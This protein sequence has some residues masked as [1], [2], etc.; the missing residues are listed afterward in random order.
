MLQK[1]NKK[2]ALFL[3]SIAL[4]L[5][6]IANIS[7]ADSVPPLSPFLVNL[8]NE[9]TP[10]VSTNLFQIPNL[11]SCLS[12]KT[13]AT[14]LFSCGT[15][16]GGGT[17]STT[18]S[19]VPGE[20][21][22]FSNN[23]TDIVTVGG[24]ST[25][26]AKFIFDPNTGV[27][28][29]SGNVVAS[30]TTATSTFTNID[31]NTLQ[32]RRFVFEGDSITSF[33]GTPGTPNTWPQQLAK[34]EP[35]FGTGQLIDV[36]QAGDTMC[37]NT[38]LNPGRGIVSEYSSQVLP[39]KPTKP[40]DEVYLFLF[41]GTNDFN[42]GSTSQQVYTNC[43][44]PYIKQAR[45]DGFKIVLMGEL[46]SAQNR[47]A[48]R[49][50]YNAL[51]S[52]NPQLY[53]YYIPTDQYLQNQNGPLFNG[54]QLHPSI[55]GASVIAGAVDYL[56]AHK[57]ESNIGTTSGQY[58]LYVPGKGAAIGT[59]TLS[60][61]NPTNAI[62]SSTLDVSG[63]SVFGQGIHNNAWSAALNTVDYGNNA[64]DSITNTGPNGSGWA[65][66][67]AD[68]NSAGVLGPAGDMSLYNWLS[69]FS[70]MTI[71]QVG[72][73]AKVSFS[74]GS[75]TA[76]SASNLTPG[77]C[78]QA[79]TGGFL[80]TISSACGAGGGGSSGGTFSTTT[81]Q[82]SGELVNHPNNNTDILAIGSN[83]TTTAPFF[84]D[85]NA[86]DM[87]IGNAVAPQL[88][89]F[90]TKNYEVNVSGNVNDIVGENIININ[91]GAQAGDGIFLS[92]NLTPRNGIGLA[93]TYYGGMAFSGSNFNGPAVGLGALPPN[94]LAVYASDGH[95]VL[96][97]A[98]TTGAIDLY[99]GA[100][101]FAGG[102]PDMKLDKTGNL[103]IGTSTPY[104][105]LSVVGSSGV[106]AD[107]YAATSTA[108][109][110]TFAGDITIGNVKIRSNTTG[111]GAE[112]AM[113][114]SLKG[115]SGNQGIDIDTLGGFGGCGGIMMN[116]SPII[117]SDTFNTLIDAAQTGSIIA[118][119][120]KN[121]GL[122]LEIGDGAGTFGSWSAD[123]G[124]NGNLYTKGAAVLGTTTI[125]G[126]GGQSII[127]TATLEIQSKLSSSLANIFQ[128]DPI[129][130]NG[131]S[132]FEIQNNKTLGNAVNAG[133]GT[134]SPG[135]ELSIGSS[136]SAFVNLSA[137]A[138]S[139]F[140]KGLNILGGCYA[141]NGNCITS[142]GGGTGGDISA[143]LVNGV[144]TI[145]NSSAN[146][147]GGDVLNVVKATSGVF[148]ETLPAPSAGEIIS[149]R[150]TPDSTNIIKLT[151]HSSD[152]IDGTSTRIMWAGESA[153]LQSDGTNWFKIAGKTIPMQ[154]QIY[155]SA[156]NMTLFSSNTSTQIPFDSTSIDT[157]GLMADLTNHRIK[158][159]RPGSYTISTVVVFYSLSAIATRCLTTPFV[160]G[161][162][163]GNSEG[164]GAVGGYPSPYYTSPGNFYAGD[165]VTLQ[166]YQSSVSTQGVY[167]FTSPA[168]MIAVQENPTW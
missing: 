126:A 120:K 108:A 47:E 112:S 114:F 149:L 137:V 4:G 10:R 9:I 153:I 5:F 80:T 6:S 96:G 88:D 168:T 123:I 43:V 91:S 64:C 18:T 87:Q 148:T 38:Q 52:G 115:P 63:I 142:G 22:N 70:A 40:S 157:T 78:V 41:A 75:T 20:L 45:A 24:S 15:G 131:P 50:S 74:Y 128:V 104:A 30:S 160:D 46:P 117:C 11:M 72:S 66:C 28:Y 62:T 140:S 77:D 55:L 60:L 166:G 81:S 89:A 133:I 84:Y 100:G 95:L 99:T 98:T 136:S 51:M 2:I 97:S 152:L 27:G 26:T 17:F 69:N 113:E 49:P 147:V 56:V 163:F 82:V 16:G 36:A 135:T 156:T 154:A 145:T 105:S 122:G 143:N 101:S 167:G 107:H 59:T 57:I 90:G 12:V 35:F 159:I 21:I 109:T 25:S 86:L 124:A 130:G 48:Q 134:T 76:L 119:G 158:I 141:V 23:N 129:G 73:G 14:G 155:L 13:D 165:V 44:V 111:T 32:S 1:R 151:Q 83:S 103:G 65:W 102:V 71:T 3:L 29:F 85:P 118:L 132:L 61:P 8:S 58:S 37:N 33:D 79:G 34:I 144:N 93:A 162:Q 125:G 94:S 138:T 164:Y 146:L 150:I 110:S 127:P 92:N 31:Y 68:S 139:T 161:N 7:S 116:S 42:D 121:A 67:A 39:F 54:D 106:V 53:D 19:Q